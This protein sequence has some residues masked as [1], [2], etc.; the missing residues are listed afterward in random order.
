M[1]DVT[2]R[3][4]PQSIGDLMKELEL[5]SQS[6]EGILTCIQEARQRLSTMEE[7]MTGLDVQAR[8]IETAVALQRLAEAPPE[9]TATHPEQLPAALARLGADLRAAINEQIANSLVEGNQEATKRRRTEANRFR[10]SRFDPLKQAVLKLSMPM[11]FLR[12]EIDG[13]PA[14]NL[15]LRFADL[16][17][18]LESLDQRLAEEEKGRQGEW[19]GAV[20]LELPPITEFIE[21]RE[22][23]EM[24]LPQIR[25]EPF[26]VLVAEVNRSIKYAMEEQRRSRTGQGQVEQELSKPF[27]SLLDKVFDLWYSVREVAGHPQTESPKALDALK[28]LGEILKA[29]DIEEIDAATGRNMVATLHKAEGYEASSGLSPGQIIKV[30]KPGYHLGDKVGRPAH[31]VAAR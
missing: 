31:V 4:I 19:D 17:S 9:P 28:L 3:N 22:I 30:V 10:S 26:A 14:R 8:L 6:Y 18:A 23:N 7:R 25:T 11:E 20:E 27:Y 15:Q 13:A 21:L 1:K 2:E 29:H 12:Y 5:Q 16:V 24:T